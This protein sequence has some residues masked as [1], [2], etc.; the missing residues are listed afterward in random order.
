MRMREINLPPLLPARACVLLIGVLALVSP[1]PAQSGPRDDGSRQIVAE[2]FTKNRIKPPTASSSSRPA[3]SRRRPPAGAAGSGPRP[4]Y[5]RVSPARPQTNSASSAASRPQPSA[6]AGDIPLTAAK[7]GVTIWRLRP[8]KG[9]DS[10]ARI[11]VQEDA[12]ETEWTPER[13]SSTTEL[14]VNDRVRLT[15][16]SPRD[17]YL[18]VVDREQYADGSFGDP[19]L[20]FPTLRTNNGENRVRP[21]R[22]VDLPAQSDNPNYFTLIPSPSRE[23]QVAE[24]LS[25]IVTTEP[26][27]NLRLAEKPLKLSKSQVEKWEK[28]WGERVEQYELEGGAGRPWSKEERDASAEGAGRYLTQEDPSPQTVYLVEGKN[29]QGLLVTV[30]LRYRR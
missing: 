13:I 2:E 17:G 19:Y 6:A 12:K 1:S 21:G 7:V 8:A 4:R 15:I 3:G 26:L 29:N 30:P 24:V 5:S 22:L 28:Q 10:G 23:D 20:I 25:I 11:L 18:Y 9:S 14:R 27:E 16:E